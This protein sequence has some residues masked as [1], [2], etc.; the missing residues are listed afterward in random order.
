MKIPKE[1]KEDEKYNCPW[2]AFIEKFPDSDKN[3]TTFWGNFDQIKISI[4]ET[5]D[6]LLEDNINQLKY[7]K[8]KRKS[9]KV[10]KEDKS[11]S[12]EE[13]RYHCLW[14]SFMG[15]YSRS[16]RDDAFWEKLDQAK[17]A[18]FEA[19]ESLRKERKHKSSEVEEFK[20]KKG[21]GYSKKNYWK[22]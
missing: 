5:L 19:C 17:D 16:D 14:C 4:L 22:K 7:D 18:F 12:S 13:E 21:V 20:K 6:S 8:K 2:C 15:R 3:N 10:K 11:E 1:K 9:K